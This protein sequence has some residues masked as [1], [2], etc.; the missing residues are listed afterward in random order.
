MKRQS[1]DLNLKNK[2]FHC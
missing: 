2:N 1:R